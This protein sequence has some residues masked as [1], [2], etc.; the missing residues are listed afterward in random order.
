[1]APT[2]RVLFLLLLVLVPTSPLKFVAC[3]VASCVVPVDIFFRHSTTPD[4]DADGGE[5]SETTATWRVRCW[6]T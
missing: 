2:Q 4:G 6:A 5:V 3:S 1:M